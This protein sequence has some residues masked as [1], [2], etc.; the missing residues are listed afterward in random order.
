MGRVQQRCAIIPF[1]FERD[2]ERGKATRDGGSS[3]DEISVDEGIARALTSLL[4]DRL[5]LLAGAGLSMAPPSSLPSAAALAQSAKQKHD[6]MFCPGEPPLSTDIEEQA[7]HFFER[8]QLATVYL[9]TLIDQNAFA[10]P[11]NPGHYSVADLLLVRAIQTAITTNVDTM[12]E[13]AGQMLFGQ[14]ASA[15]DGISAAA[16]PPNTSPLL[17]LHGCR[18]ADPANMGPRATQRGPGRSAH[19]VKQELVA[20]AAD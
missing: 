17:K 18:S 20:W 12:I 3:L 19:R 1:D 13:T 8:G 9:R 10:A 4:T 15:V 11:P 14:V 6:A 16:F 5:A 2:R 7:Q